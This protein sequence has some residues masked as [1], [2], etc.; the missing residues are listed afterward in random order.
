MKLLSNAALI[1]KLITSK[2]FRDSYTYEHVRNG[3]SF[4]IRAM[5]DERGWTQGKLGEI[6]AKPRNVITRLEDPN[7]GK[8]TIKTLLEI[9][10]AFDVALL[11]R[12]IPFSKLLREY[13]DT[14]S[15]A[16]VARSI[17]KEKQQLAKWVQSKDK[18]S[19]ADL[20]GGLYQLPLPL[21]DLTNTTDSKFTPKANLIFF[22]ESYYLEDHVQAAPKIHGD[23][24]GTNDRA[25]VAVAVQ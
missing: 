9:A 18:A 16:L 14:S 7:Y 19:N 20:A 13:E 23:D 8:F 1:A 21:D 15:S 25:W 6:T 3:I 4:Q 12:F 11:I 10:S 5:R 24:A 17:L 2:T 22:P